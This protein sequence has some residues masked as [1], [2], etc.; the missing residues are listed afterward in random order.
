MSGKSDT[1]EEAVRWCI[2]GGC[3]FIGV[4]LVRRLRESDVRVRLLDNLS[5]GSRKDLAA[6]TDFTEFSV[7]EA[8]TA[9]S[10]GEGEP[11][12]AVELMVGDI[13]DAED[14]AR[15][16]QG[17]S[18]VVHLAAQTGVI[19]SVEDPL[20]DCQQNVIGTLTMLEA[21]RKAGTVKRFILA[22]S[23]APLGDQEPPIHEGKVP[24]PV[25]PYG[26]SKLAGEG[27]CS[28]YHG[29]FGLDTVVLRFSNVYGPYSF[30]KGSVVAVFFRNA[31]A[32]QPLV[33]YGDGHQ[34]RDFLYV[35]DLCEAIVQSADSAIGGEV[36]QI[37]TG[38]ETSVLSLVELV[39]ERVEGAGDRKVR[40]DHQPP[41]AGEILNS[42][43]DISKARQLIGY[44]P[45][46][47]LTQGLDNT[48][49]WFREGWKV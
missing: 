34:T 47:S 15:A 21:A 31:L 25:A 4:N 33:I 28:A 41:R 20:W 23:S 30:K 32:G 16:V 19:P 36:M 38:Q 39:K 18:V 10:D 49:E 44:D 24:R 29:S 45:Q 13:R 46:M 37:A 26:A 27:Y 17:C 1:S 2:T 12:G 35:G 40:I 5:A 9:A 11:G 43:S 6:V 22:S 8:T 48:W 42:V 7:D 14:A 3:G